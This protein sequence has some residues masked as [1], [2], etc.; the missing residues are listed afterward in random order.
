MQ[1][2]ATKKIKCKGGSTSSMRN[3]LRKKDNIT[4]AAVVTPERKLEV[5]KLIESIFKTKDPVDVVLAELISCDGLTFRI[6]L[7]SQCLRAAL[8]AQGYKLPKDAK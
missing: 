4:F 5:I 2:S 7:T 6:F 3:H 1:S 8:E